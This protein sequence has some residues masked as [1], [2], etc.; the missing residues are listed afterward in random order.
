MAADQLLA[1]LDPL[2]AGKVGPGHGA[3]SGWVNFED[4]EG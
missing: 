3:F 2:A 1:N 4:L